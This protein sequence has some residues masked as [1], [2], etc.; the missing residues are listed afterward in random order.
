MIHIVTRCL[1]KKYSVLPIE[2][3]NK[4]ENIYNYY[5]RYQ[6]FTFVKFL[7]S[8]SDPK[9]FLIVEMFLKNDA[10]LKKKKIIYLKLPPCDNTNKNKTLIDH[11]FVQDPEDLNKKYK[12]EFELTDKPLSIQARLLYFNDEKKIITRV[13][14]FNIFVL[15]Q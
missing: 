11:Y 2:V 13:E 8:N 3:I 7:I 15:P 12:C 6:K 10:V 9:Q 1:D 14:C 4:Q 5:I